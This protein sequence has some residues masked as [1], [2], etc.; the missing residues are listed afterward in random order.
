MI[1]KIIYV[2]GILSLVLFPLVAAVS[3]TETDDTNDIWH[4]KWNESS[5][6]YSWEESTSNKPNIDIRELSYSSEYQQ[7]T[8]ELKVQG[9]IQNSN[10]TVYYVFCNTTDATYYMSYSNGQGGCIGTSTVGSGYSLGNVTASG[11]TITATVNTV[12]TGTTEEFYG[13][14]AEY[15][16]LGDTSAE[17]WGDW[18]PQSL[19]PWYGINDN[20]DG[21]GDGG[22]GT[23]GFELVVI[24]CALAIAIVIKR[25][26]SG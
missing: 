12:G 24:A 2:G 16:T 4:Y 6:T 21:D 25:K 10:D 15:T 26:N 22:D 5:D 3:E 14:A 11:N 8:L 17:W 20:G 1:K 7:L 19:S 18:A 13:W 9:T 23:P